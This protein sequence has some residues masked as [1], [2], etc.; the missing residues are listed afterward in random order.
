[1]LERIREGSQGVVAKVVLGLVILTFAVSGIGSY[2][3][4]QAETSVATV[5]DTEISQQTFDTAYQNERAR[6]EQQ[7]G[8]MAEQLF[9]DESYLANF[10]QGVLDRLIVEELQRQNA[11][12]LG[13]RV[14]DEQINKTILAM[15]EFQMNG[16]FNQDAYVAILRQA[17]YTPASFREFMRSQMAQNQY[18]GAVFGTEFVLP[19]EEAA[20][21]KL[22]AQTRSF[23]MIE[24]DVQKLK[25]DVVAEQT[26]LDS[27][28]AANKLNYQ[29]PEKVSVEYILIDSALIAKDVAVTEQDVEDYYQ[30]NLLE[31]TK[32]EQRRLAHILVESGDD[33][34]AKINQAKAKLDSGADFGEI[35]K[36][37]STDTFSAENGGDLEW[38]EPGVMGEKFD[39]AAF[40]L[41][42]VG[43]V[44][45]VVET[46]FGFHI[47]KLTDLKAEEVK[48]LAEVAQD[49][50]DQI[51]TDK[52]NELYVEAQTKAIETAFEIPDT[53]EDAA[54][55]AGLKV[56]ST[57]LLTREQLPEVLSEL[58]V[59]N[60]LFDQSFIAEGINS[61]LIELTDDR[62]L[63][64]RV[65]EHQASEQQ[66]L[67]DVKDTITEIVVLNKA[68]D[69][70]TAKANEVLAKVQA[71]EALSAQG[72][73]VTRK[74]DVL[75]SDMSLDSNVRVEL[76]SIA[77]PAEGSVEY[78]VVNKAN[79]NA[80]V[81]GLDKVGEKAVQESTAAAQLASL[82][83]RVIAQAYIDAMKGNAQIVTS[84]N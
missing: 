75:R 6:M 21:D 8:A 68:K 44:T 9:A 56:S 61:D 4:S 64:V 15:S 36:E 35:A 83:N 20:F 80:V 58:K 1:M 78:A 12:K 16:Q 52:A 66:S 73:P 55:V 47:I 28:F 48:T 76:F 25:A 60:Q 30:A 46:D 53:L 10:R 23:D 18:S 70:A 82:V 2:V 11:D 26:D 40:A 63:L 29:T 37:F 3:N 22:N 24:F 27:Y 59:A 84:L 77:K 5:N 71:G 43:D 33:A 51:A 17:G 79:G 65:V 50:R 74:Y 19:S 31:F 45:D 14:G 57:D 39:Q 54:Q 81:L 13:I 7:F 69:L 42:N 32:E 34:E 49:I 62:S 41:K 72:E 67:E 38:V